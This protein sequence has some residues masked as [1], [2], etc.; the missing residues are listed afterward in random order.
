M[1]GVIVWRHCVASLCDAIVMQLTCKSPSVGFQPNVRMT[2]PNSTLVM[3]PPPSRSKKE[4]TSRY[5]SILSSDN[6][7]W[8]SS[9]SISTS[10]DLKMK[11]QQFLISFYMKARFHI[12][13]THLVHARLPKCNVMQKRACTWEVLM[14]LLFDLKMKILSFVSIPMAY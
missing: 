10:I 3:V 12:P 2:W 7:T 14:R 9:G 6:R 4:K 11:T 1:C 8:T 5:S 13:F